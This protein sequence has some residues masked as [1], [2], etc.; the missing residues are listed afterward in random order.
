MKLLVF[1]SGMMKNLDYDIGSVSQQV[2]EVKPDE[3]IIKF[4]GM[5]AGGK[6]K[7]VQ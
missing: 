1:E 2:Q 5:N 3:D 6:T 4:I 7:L